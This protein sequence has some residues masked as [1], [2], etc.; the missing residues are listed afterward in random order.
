MRKGGSIWVIDCLAYWG[1][2]KDVDLGL[3]QAGH[4]ETSKGT[5]KDR[6]VVVTQMDRVQL[7][8]A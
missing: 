7:C 6:Y 2:G 1:M 5:G 3:V 8:H 4:E